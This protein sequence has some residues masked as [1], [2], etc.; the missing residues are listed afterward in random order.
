MAFTQKS[1]FFNEIFA[2]PSSISF[3]TVVS[4]IIP[5][6]NVS[7]ELFDTKRVKNSSRRTCACHTTCSGRGAQSLP[8]RQFE[9]RLL[10]DLSMKER[11]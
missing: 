3:S 1:I 4:E 7:Q 8:A 9:L 2:Q 10:H 5:Y 6:S 11:G